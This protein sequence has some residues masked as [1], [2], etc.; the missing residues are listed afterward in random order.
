[1]NHCNDKTEQ[2]AKFAKRYDEKNKSFKLQISENSYSDYSKSPV[3]HISVSDV[4]LPQ[5]VFQQQSKAQCR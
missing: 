1:M 2:G 3:T 4:L 5:G